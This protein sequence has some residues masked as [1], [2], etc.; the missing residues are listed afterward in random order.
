MAG[1]LSN[2]KLDFL[3]S[4]ALGAVLG[5]P[6]CLLCGTSATADGLCGDCRKVL[7][8]LPQERCPTCASPA[9]GSQTCGRCLAHPPALDRVEAALAY[10]FPVDGLVQSLKYRHHLAAATAL[11]ELLAEAVAG[12]PMP[13]VLVPVPLGKQRLRERGF[14]QSLEIARVAARRLELAVDASALRRVRDTPAQVSLAFDARAK[15]VRG[16]FVCDAALAGAR[17]ALVDDVL[18]TGASLDE[19]AKALRKAGASEVLGWV[20]ART[21]LEP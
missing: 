12:S 3:N 15:N 18:T 2:L 4:R 19:C 20:A 6:V 11:G 14:N 1:P 16:A 21:L 8:Q 5:T 17:V 9:P 10:A 7:P 13:E